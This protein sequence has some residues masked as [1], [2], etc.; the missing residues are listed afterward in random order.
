MLVMLLEKLVQVK[1][2]GKHV[3]VMLNITMPSVY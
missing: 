2:L 3:Y 1:L